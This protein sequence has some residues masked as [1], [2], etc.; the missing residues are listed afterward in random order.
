MNRLIYSAF[1]SALLV[2]TMG[3]VL[4][5]GAFYRPKTVNQMFF[6]GQFPGRHLVHNLT[7]KSNV[8]IVNQS[9][10]SVVIVIATRA[11]RSQQTSQTNDL[12]ALPENNV[13]RGT[14][15]GFIIDREGY[16][17]T[18]EHVIKE[19]DRIRVKLADGREYRASVKGVDLG[20]DLAL[21]KIEAEGLTSLPL[22]DSKA[23]QVGDPVI[24]IGNPLEYEYS[25]TAGI[26][27]A[28][29]RKIYP[30]KPYL[31]FIQT[32][33]AINRGNS[34]G[35]LLNQRGEVIAVN[36]VIRV[37]GRGISFAVPSNLVKQVIGQLRAYGFVARGFLG[38]TPAN[39]TAEYREGLGLGDVQGILVT[40]VS[41]DKPA[42]RAGIKTYDVITYFDGRR[43]TRT[44]EFFG[45]VANTPPQQKVELIVMRSGQQL[46][47]HATLATR[48]EERPVGLRP[49]AQKS[50]LLLGFSV[51]ENTPETL[52]ESRAGQQLPKKEEEGLVGVVVSEIDPLGPAADSSLSV[53]MVIVEANRHP[54]A[55]LEDFNK[56][57][58]QLN[59]GGALVL[60]LKSPSQNDLRL[61]AIRVGES[62]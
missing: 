17:V 61:V 25:V 47:L 7:R 54:I 27:S 52:R 22:G 43:V 55:K 13:L 36:T 42:D 37:D 9:S 21:L 30:E 5:A 20:T 39:I 24:A 38:L 58:S 33:A 31:D 11:T 28:K 51:R 2:G 4:V 18:N 3:M 8:E 60:R 41:Q 56:V 45:Y 57:T 10:Q 50:G 15:T 46:K 59:N 32:D 48:D 49:A 12:T 62:R 6:S 19:A 44:D 26:V 40:E 1:F 34:G 23:V 16:I 35:P 14:G 29:D 53:G